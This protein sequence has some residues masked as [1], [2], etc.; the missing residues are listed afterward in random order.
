MK[1]KRIEKLNEA[2]NRKMEKDTRMRR[3]LK[4]NRQIKN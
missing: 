4:L 1:I 3:K 2:L